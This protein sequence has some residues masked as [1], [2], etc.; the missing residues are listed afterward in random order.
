MQRLFVLREA[1]HLASVVAFLTQH[2]SIFAREG[3]FLAVTVSLF[4]S[5]RSLA[6]NRRYFGAVLTR[7]A[8]Q[9]WPDARQYSVEAW[10]EYFKRRFIGVLDLP[11][12]ATAAMSSAEL[13]V[14][15]F[16]IFMQN[17]EAYAAAELGICFD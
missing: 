10:H 11:G 7:I 1:R 5:R 17:V 12:G 6:Q 9:A 8:E 16:A 14:E 13:G 3:K 2:W 4:Q 15:E